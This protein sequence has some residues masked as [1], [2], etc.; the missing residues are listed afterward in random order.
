[1]EAA[2]ESRRNVNSDLNF[3]T[4]NKGQPLLIMNQ[5]IYKCNKKTPNKKYWVC[6]VKDCGVYVH[7]DIDQ[8][9]LSGGKTDHEHRANPE[10]VQVKKTREQIK[11][12]VLNEFTPIGKIFS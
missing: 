9:Y 5:Y 12:L 10:S 4:S 2:T 1:M 6:V 3:I 11:Q 7:T 8:N